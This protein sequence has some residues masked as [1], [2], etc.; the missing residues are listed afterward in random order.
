MWLKY[1]DNGVEGSSRKYF[2][3]SEIDVLIKDTGARPGDMVFLVA[4]SEKVCFTSMGQLR[5]ELG[6]TRKI[7]Q[8]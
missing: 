2:S 5:L 7:D 8:K 3:D 1:T 6:K 4:A